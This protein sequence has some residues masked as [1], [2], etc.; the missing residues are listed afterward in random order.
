MTERKP[1]WL[2]L[3]LNQNQLVKFSQK[4]QSIHPKRNNQ[5]GPSNEHCV[6]K[7]LQQ[8]EAAAVEKKKEKVLERWRKRES[9]KKGEL[10][11]KWR[12]VKLKDSLTPTAAGRLGI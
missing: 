12:G 1:K 8:V 9:W 11:V 3:G 10:L 2:L 6:P 4:S 5:V 7:S